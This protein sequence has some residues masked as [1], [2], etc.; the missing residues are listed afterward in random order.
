M[1]LTISQKP[2]PQI[3]EYVWY[4]AYGSNLFKSRFLCYIKGAAPTE[5]HAPHPGCRDDSDPT[6][7]MIVTCG[8]PVV[9]AGSTSSWGEGGVAFLEIA[10]SHPQTPLRLWRVTREQ[11]EDI[12]AMENGLQPGE[13][14]LDWL[15][16]QKQGTMF[17]ADRG[18]YRQAVY[19]GDVQGIPVVT[20]TWAESRVDLNP[21]SKSYAQVIANGFAESGWLTP[22]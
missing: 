17:V 16:L 5:N 11:F 12:C 2:D 7:D 4:A 18:W 20:F 3:P 13:I 10:G 9:Y 6:D 22:G 19:L 8:Y 14:Q 21:P 1:N 15:T